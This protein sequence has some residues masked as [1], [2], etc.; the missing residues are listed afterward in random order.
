MKDP[1]RPI[2]EL[3]GL[4]TR[5]RPEYWAVLSDAPYPK[6]V[7]I[8]SRLVWGSADR[9][10]W[11]AHRDEVLADWITRHPGTRPQSWWRFEM[12]EAERR[13]VGGKGSVR[14]K[15]L[16]YGI[17]RYWSIIYNFCP[18]VFESQ[19]SFLKRNNLLHPGEDT[20]LS[21]IDYMPA[22]LPHEWWPPELGDGC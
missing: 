21:P 8:L 22:V 4:A 5:I 6:K 17:P 10:L 9:R 1:A 20:L 7:G 15:T 19:A 12:P 11:S 16:S 18:P 13:L 14:R 2:S 3:S